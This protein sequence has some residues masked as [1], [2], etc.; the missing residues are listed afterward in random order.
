MIQSEKH[1]EFIKK[2]MKCRDFLYYITE[3]DRMATVYWAANSLKMLKDPLF[4]QIRPQVIQFVYS[5]LKTNGGFG[6]NPEYSSNVVSTFNAL[7]LLFLYNVP[8][9][10]IKTVKFLLSLQNLSG[11]FTFD[12][13]G[14]ID[15]RFD[16]CAI[17]SLHLLSIMKDYKHIDYSK[18][19][20]ICSCTADACDVFSLDN[21]AA[22]G[23]EHKI[24]QYLSP[25][26]RLDRRHLSE[27]IDQSFLQDVGLDIDITLRHLVECFN[28]DG[29]VGQFKGSESHAAQTFCAL[30][31]LRSLGHLEAIDKLKTVDFLMYRQLPNGGLCG[32]IGKKEDVCYSFWAFSSMA[33]L[34]SEYINL[35]KLQEFIFSCEGDEGGFSDRPG[36]EP[37]LYH[38]MFSLASLSLLGNKKL[39]NIDPGFAI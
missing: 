26:N 11:A 25:D 10:D 20:A 31:S 17:L 13:Y 8:Y 38:L 1:I 23:M 32:R 28:Y 39:D 3:Q 4:E 30:S 34:E 19:I 7:Q 36:N 2:T 29:G 22:D 21:C 5:C 16:C 9:Y 37:D 33:I 14:D 18:G 15:T 24:C 12:A 6:P 27:P 35:E